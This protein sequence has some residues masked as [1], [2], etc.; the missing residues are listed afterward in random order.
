LYFSSDGLIGMGGLDIFKAKP[1]PDG[2]WIVS[3][4]ETTYKTAFADDFCI[5][6]EDG[7]EKG[8]FQLNTEGKGKR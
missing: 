2:S 7:N 1:Q 4:H 3:E 8:I 5:A 6:F